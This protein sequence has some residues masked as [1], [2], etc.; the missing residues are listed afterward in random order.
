M[1]RVI[2]CL[3]V[4]VAVSSFPTATFAQSA[5]GRVA[6]GLDYEAN[7]LYGNFRDNQFWMSGDLFF[8][9]NILDWLSLHAAYN[10]GQLR[11]RVNDDNLN[12]YA[13]YFGQK[14]AAYYPIPGTTTNSEIARETY[15]KIRHSGFQLM[16]STNLFP[17]ETF[18]PYVIGGIEAL[19]FEPRNLDQDKALPYLAAVDYSRNTFGEVVGIG[20]ELYISENLVFSG[21]GLVHFT[22]TD[23]LDD[24][25]QEAYDEFHKQLTSGGSYKAN[26]PRTPSTTQDVFLTFG[27]GF[28]YYIA[29]SLDA[30]KD[31]LSDRAEREVYHTDP[32]NPDTDGDGLSDGDEVFTYHT[33]PTKADTDGDGLSDSDELMRYHTNP[34]TADT[35]DDGLTDGQEVKVYHTNALKPDTDGDLLP[36]GDEINKFKTDPLKVDTDGDGLNDGDEV[37]RYG[38]D[39]TKTDSDGDGLGDGDEV[40]KYHTNPAKMDTD[41]DGLSDRDEIIEYRTDP[42]RADTDGDGLSDYDEIN[43]TKTDPL[44][45]DTDGDGFNDGVDKCPLTPGVAPD[46]CPPKQAANTVTNF[47]GILFIVNTDHFDL[48]QPATLEN[49]YKIR[50]LVNQCPDIKVVIEGHASSEGKEDRNKVLSEARAESVRKWLTDQGVDSTRI[51]GIEG[52][53]SSKPIIPEPKGHKNV[54]KQML[55]KARAQN[56]RI[57]IR[58]V[59]PC[60]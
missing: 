56:R 26:P 21:K 54:S 48:S 5:A 37:H 34:T 55:E 40:L 19:N 24:F 7:K 38:T 31:G 49:L 29:G 46:G 20:Y 57:A 39:P 32:Y 25:S 15:S 43:K 14:G 47:P 28:S 35:D 6:F 23:Y 30:D 17:T 13:D 60:K 22:N 1:K 10:A 8:R 18:V 50:E 42:T 44:K 45:P 51:A 33:D 52:F 41:D 11:M 12:T 4:L 59:Q 36:D 58:V 16:L 27:V 3:A 2:V 53:G 9:W